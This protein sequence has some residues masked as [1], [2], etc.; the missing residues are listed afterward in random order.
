MSAFNWKIFEGFWG[1]KRNFL[2]LDKGYH[3]YFND[4]VGSTNPIYI[5]DTPLQCFLEIRNISIISRSLQYIST[6]I[7]CIQRIKHNENM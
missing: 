3:N 2:D 1:S 7:M 6:S 5:P 4:E